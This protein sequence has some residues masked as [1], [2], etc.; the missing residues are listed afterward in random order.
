MEV[1]VT[2]VMLPIVIFFSHFFF[3]NRTN[4]KMLFLET[5]TPV[6]LACEVF[7]LEIFL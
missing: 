7:T 4:H 6:T 1:N 5:V 2:F 3:I